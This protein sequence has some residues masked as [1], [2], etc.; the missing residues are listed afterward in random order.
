VNKS[1]NYVIAAIVSLIVM[2]LAYYYPAEFFL[3]F[4][5]FLS[6]G[7]PVILILF[8]IYTLLIKKQERR[9]KI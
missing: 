5:M 2:S 1:I 3:S 4:V 8:L 6:P 7:I 9:V